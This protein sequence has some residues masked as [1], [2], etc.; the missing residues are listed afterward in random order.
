MAGGLMPQGP[1]FE[2]AITR[3]DNL[4][5]RSRLV[6]MLRH[7]FEHRVTT[8]VAAA[9]Y[10]KTTAL[11]L[12]VESNR[13]DPLGRDVSIALT[14]LDA[15]P[16]RLLGAILAAFGLEAATDEATSLR[17]IVDAAWSAAP[18]EVVLIID[19]AHHLNATPC[20]EVLGQLLVELPANAHIVLASR[21]PV[22]VPV[23]RLRAHGQLGEITASDLALDDAELRDL[24]ERRDVVGEE[25]ALPR[26]AATADLRLAA[27]IDAGADFLW[28]E[29]LSGLDSDRLA[30]LRRIVVLDEVD[31]ELVRS[32]TDGAFDAATLFTDLPMIERRTGG[33]YRMHAILREALL[34]RLEPGERRKA[35]AI[36]AEA[37]RDRQHLATAIRLFH[38]AGDDI[39]ALDTA[40]EF[41]LAPVVIQ[42]VATTREAKVIV[43]QIDPESPVALLLDAGSRYAGLE[44]HVIPMFRKAA[45]AARS[46]GDST[47]EAL[48]LHRVVQSGLLDHDVQFADD[49]ARISELSSEDGF[50]AGVEAYLR[51]IDHQ[52]AGD[53]DAAVEDLDQLAH[54]G[55]AGEL[56]GRA[57]R[58]CDLG[59]PEEVAIGLGP[60]ALDDLP[61]G[62]DLFI[63]LAM[64]W[65]GEADP[66]VAVLVAE[67]T[68]VDVLRQGFTHPCVSMLST[69]AFIAVA[70]GDNDRAG[71][72]IA[73]AREMAADGVGRSIEMLIDV[74]E[75]ALHAVTESDAAAEVALAA[76][77][78]HEMS[79]EWPSRPQLFSLPLVYLS[80][81]DMRPM[82]D[83]LPF[84]PSLNTAVA[85]G[86]ALV[87]LREGDPGPAGH[88][89]WSRATLLRVH[90]LPH[91]LVELACGALADGHE[92]ARDVLDVVPHAADHLSRV[93]GG[94]GPAAAI[95]MKIVGATPMPEPFRLH[96]RTLGPVTLSRDGVDIDAGAF[97]KR[98]KVRELFA[99]LLERGRLTRS[100]ATGFLWPDHDD[101][102]KAASSLR[103]TLSTLNDVL[104]P[105]R[106]RGE[107][108]FHLHADTESIALDTR[109]TTDLAEFEALIDAAQ[110]DDDAGLPARALEEYRQAMSLY[111][112]DYLEGVDASWIVLTRLRLRSLAVNATCRIAELTAAKGEPEQAA[113]WAATARTFDPLNERAGRLF[114]AALDAAGDR[115]AARAAAAELLAT[116]TDADL[117]ASGPTLRLVERLR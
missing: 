49:L 43:N 19:D 69:A 79:L 39:S 73:H 6:S 84:G 54:L 92:Q 66:E 59:R 20:I 109:V 27:G 14:P 110:S 63:A 71:R 18:D 40:R 51:S 112:G 45:D 30:H 105:A 114:V 117:T 24:R 57:T 44:H 74:A 103:T 95:A 28:E 61:P 88:L 47:L 104:D 34:P 21:V 72:H 35:L 64:W 67:A 12:A 111:R 48:A 25:L 82:L 91:H 46:I 75:A 38:E 70:A 77:R 50:A 1:R 41:T 113:R 7:R 116:L 76:T 85:A 29:I 33:G 108:A 62:A 107:A 16:I 5:S 78:P 32:I 100:D 68:L 81:P 97:T 93:A 42:G 65:R 87:A 55:H 96:A 11:A 86:Q 23:A 17:R 2:P 26:H 15:D 101:D 52:I 53:A 36:A 58:L 99:L 80:R 102:D 115:S 31:D 8:V 60:E 10:G 98:P 56:V 3:R 106:R 83:R 94:D 4:V 22:D 37:E 90:V 89:P 13:L 9:G